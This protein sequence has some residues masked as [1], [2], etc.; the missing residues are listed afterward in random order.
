MS[1]KSSMQEL[2]AKVK[3]D[4]AES[5][6]EDKELEQTKKE[7]RELEQKAKVQNEPSKEGNKSISERTAVVSNDLEELES[8][9]T[10]PSIDKSLG[11]LIKKEENKEVLE[12]L[13]TLYKEYYEVNKTNIEKSIKNYKAE[14]IE[15]LMQYRD[16]MLNHSF[17]LSI[18]HKLVLGDLSDEK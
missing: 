18:V 1:N 14:D 9:K 5:I 15:G 13:V 17:P 7:Q 6:E 3:D 10:K 8:I 4:V 12:K 16:D 11:S 2:L